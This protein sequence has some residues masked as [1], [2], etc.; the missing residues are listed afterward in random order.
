[1]WRGDVAFARA[2]SGQTIAQ[3]GLWHHRGG[4]LTRLAHGAVPGECLDIAGCKRT[5]RGEV[6][7]LDYTGAGVAFVWDVLAPGVEGA[8]DGRIVRR[9]PLDGAI[10]RLVDEG[11]GDG[12]RNRR[13][14]TADERIGHETLPSDGVPAG[15]V[16]TRRSSYFLS[17]IPE[18]SRPRAGRR[19][20]NRRAVPKQAWR[21]VERDRR[22][23]TTARAAAS[24]A[25]T[26]RRIP[27]SWT[28]GAGDLDHRV[29]R[30][31]GQREWL[32]GAAHPLA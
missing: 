12:Q 18:R 10:A 5:R 2:T 24:V 6:Q 20:R 31:A 25:P 30:R 28:V 14:R 4:T 21:N 27:N 22:R 29:P 15:A 16:R 23:R 13:E 7:K 11:D 1:M 3:L 32:T 9:A 8:G 17:V 19:S 26:D